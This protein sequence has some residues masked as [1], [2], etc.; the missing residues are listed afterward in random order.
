MS[1]RGPEPSEDAPV[2]KL[3]ILFLEQIMSK[4]G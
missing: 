3:L 1:L 4:F 2:D